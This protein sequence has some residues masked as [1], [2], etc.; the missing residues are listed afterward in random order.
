MVL[1]EGDTVYCYDSLGEKNFTEG[2]GYAVHFLMSATLVIYDDE[3]E[4]WL[5]NQI[6]E[7][8]FGKRSPYFGGCWTERFVSE[9]QWKRDSLIELLG[10]K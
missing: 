8:P 7:M 4:P 1:K 9:A 3:K 6:G 10:I 5:F 2:K